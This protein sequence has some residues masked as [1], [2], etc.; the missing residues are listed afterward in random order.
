MHI[1]IQIVMC[2]LQCEQAALYSSKFFSL[3]FYRNNVGFIGKQRRVGEIKQ[4]VYRPFVQLIV[5]RAKNHLKTEFQIPRQN[6]KRV[7]RAAYLT[8]A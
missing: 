7:F 2:T 4:P 5:T 3:P 1:T 8:Y 6:G